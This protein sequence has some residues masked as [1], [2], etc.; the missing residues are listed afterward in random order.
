MTN[1]L[2]I[3]IGGFRPSPLDAPVVKG[4]SS[5]G[6]SFCLN[7]ASPDDASG[8]L[9]F[10][11]ENIP[12]WTTETIKLDRADWEALLIGLAR[13]WSSIRLEETGSVRPAGRAFRLRHD[14]AAWMS[15]RRKFPAMWLIRDGNYMTIETKGRKLRWAFSDVLRT[16]ERLG[17]AISTRLVKI[18]AAPSKAVP[19]WGE[20]V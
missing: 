2:N 10:K 1:D 8:D 6:L 16:L 3:P 14:L 19:L 5:N 9:L 13:A 17:E 20:R 12:A 11:I 15:P 4:G 7:W 18:D